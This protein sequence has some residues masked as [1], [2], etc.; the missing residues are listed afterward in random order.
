MLVVAYATGD[1][2]SRPIAVGIPAALIFTG[3][4]ALEGHV[5]WPAWIRFVGDASYSI[6]LVHILV[7]YRICYRI[8]WLLLRHGWLPVSILAAGVITA[9]T[10]ILAGPACFVAVERPFLR[11][12]QR[13][14]GSQTRRNNMPPMIA[15]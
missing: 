9:I 12:L 14:H 7:V 1:S 10:A 6:Y 4:L 5:R 11:K 2:L 8:L 3:F 15:Q 13:L